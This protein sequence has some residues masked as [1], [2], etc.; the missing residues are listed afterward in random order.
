MGLVDYYYRFESL[1]LKLKQ[2]HNITSDYRLDC[3][4]FVDTEVRLS[5]FLNTEGK[6]F[7]YKRHPPFLKITSDLRRQP[8]F[9]L[10]NGKGCPLTGVLFG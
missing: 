1:P 5:S 10:V 2:K 4:A 7:F 9:V 8:E 6:L 3:T